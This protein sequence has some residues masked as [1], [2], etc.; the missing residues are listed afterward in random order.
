LAGISKIIKKIESFLP[1]VLAGDRLAARR[2][3]RYLARKSG[4]FKPDQKLLTRI[5]RLENRLQA[6]VQKRNRRRENLP[7]LR[8]NEE[9]PIF[10]KKDEIIQ[11]IGGQRVI[12][13]SGET[14]SGKTTQLPQFCLAAGR[15]IDG[16]IGCTQPRRIAATTVARRIAEEL[17]QELGNAV[18]YK[19]R[20]RDRTARDSYI[21]MMTDGIL[22]AE[23]QSDRFLSA[24]DT[25]IVDEAHERSL[26]IDFILGILR[27][28]IRKRDDLKLIITSATIDTEKFS[29]A[30]DDAP[31]IEVSGRMYPV[32]IQYPAPE[33]DPAPENELTHVETA[34]RAIKRVLHQSRT[35]DILVFMPT[36][37]DIRETCELIEAENP[38]G[39]RV[40][41]LFA[42]LTATEQSRVFARRAERKIIVATN[43]AETSITIPGI[44]YVI[45]S[46][47]ARISRYSP[48]TRTTSLP[49][50]AVSK[51]SCDQRKGRCGRVQ[52]GV[53][54]RLYPED[55]YETRPQFTPPEI[56]RANLAEVILRMISLKL[57][58]VSKFPFI[59]RPD[60]KSIKDGFD[61]LFELGALEQRAEDRW[62][63]TEDRGQRPAVR[64]QMAEVEGHGEGKRF[65]VSGVRAQG[66]ESMEPGVALEGK[67]QGRAVLTEKGRLMA[68]IPLDPRLSR[69]LIE[70]GKERCIG[71]M[72]IIVAALS[73]QDPRERPVEKARE[74]DRGHAA[75]HDA[76]SDFVTLLNIWH[77]Y[78]SHRQKVKSNNQMKRF[79]REHFLSFMRM[80]EWR[81]IHHQISDILKE[82]GMGKLACGMRKKRKG[83]NGNAE[84]GMRNAEKKGSGNGKWEGGRRL[85][86]HREIGLR[87]EGQ[88]ENR[89]NV[90]AEVRGRK[91]ETELGTDLNSAF[92]IPNSTFEA[93]HKS[94]LS[95]FLSN[96]AQ[97]KD[98]NIYRATKGREVMIFPGSGLF[99]KA[100]NWIVAE[101]MIETSR[102]FARTV[103]NIDSDWLEDL[104][105]D[106][107]R[108]TYLDPHWERNRGEVVASEQVS[109][110]GLIIV[111][112]RKVSYGKVNAAEASSIF[113]QRALVNGDVKKPF[114]FMEYNLQL[115]D[116][117]KGIENRLRRRDLL[118]DEQKMF[119]FYQEKLAGIFDLRSLAKYLRRKDNDHFLRMKKETLLQ[120]PPDNAEMGQYPTRL[121]IEQHAFECSY[122]FDPGKDDDGVTVKV[123]TTLAQ[124]VSPEA[125]DWLV[126]G[127]YPEKIEVLIKGLPKAYRKK[128]VPV[129]NTVDIIVRDMPKGQNSLVSALGD[130]IYRRFGVDIPA[131][132]WSIE[133]LP[134]YLKMRISITSPEGKELRAGRNAAL[135]RQDVGGRVKSD[136]FEAARRKWEKRGITRWDF[137]DL[138]E[139]VSDS[140][141]KK[142]KWVAYPAL[143][144]DSATHKSA[145]LCLFR[146]QVNAI[147]AH[148][149]GV[150]TLY[151]IHFAKN[152]KLLKRH[153]ILPADIRFTADYFGGPNELLQQMYDRVIEELF[154]KNIRSEKVFYAHA[155]SAAVK[156]F[157]TGQELRA[158]T[159]PLLTAYHD[160]RSRI[161]E[162]QQTNRTNS[163]AVSFFE[164]LTRDLERL[165]PQTFIAIYDIPRLDHLP[166]FIQ[167]AAIRARRA[168]VDFEKDRAK[169]NE[170]IKFTDGLDQLLKEL[171]PA[172]SD[173]K[174]QAIE[175]YF[176]MVEEYKVSVFAQELKTAIPISAKRL[177]KKLKEIGRMA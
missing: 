118:V 20:F 122:C 143:E 106:L 132:A 149:A 162:L 78:H 71:E 19:I 14:G 51:S 38:Q 148:R 25:I 63:K 44:K 146:R 137:G 83:G 116:E 12:V 61:L 142:A 1:Q 21:K 111:P 24:Y 126:P 117:I 141:H 65:Q 127:L 172:I 90:N 109:L 84:C 104:G 176:W 121:D 17:R 96:I 119:E 6:S 43:V 120:Y 40:M 167:A 13:V 57:G 165:V 169:S 107:C 76:Q 41:P 28:L 3:I 145:N 81:D 56:L 164:G 95:G 7:R 129:K 39:T 173:E 33:A 60:L 92:R 130:F 134:D 101:E 160:A 99:N 161:Y 2:E 79:C 22:L 159:I 115:I 75:F 154:G 5:N 4:K 46:G 100:K 37:Q 69:M 47:L 112:A 23:T 18:G 138:P 158:K 64:V 97:K 59:D 151:G 155:E 108:R 15:G 136:E 153:L 174:R 157:P 85:P 30:F 170:I 67:S 68:R 82:H 16:L 113:I 50:M 128:L 31:V 45:D 94:V 77:R 55:D 27:T 144:T 74:A 150:A 125:I 152:L 114:A 54:I 135:L 62:R 102:L 105:G 93:I 49:V 156:I 89:G 36:E 48:R 70:A 66:S 87:P 140:G 110:F 166:R 88:G 168:V 42:R 133:S 29:R 91:A 147:A 10:S 163:M 11:A 8:F 80:R 177:D 32:D 171:S 26:N 35:G 73:I 86:A 131:A 124:S 103:A 72:T 139:F 9:L 123:P 98:N 53:C 52:N 34:A 58:D 175:A